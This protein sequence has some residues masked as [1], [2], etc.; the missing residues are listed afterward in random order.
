MAR[1]LKCDTDIT[2]IALC[3]I[4]FQEV[5]FS[6]AQNGQEISRVTFLTMSL[7]YPFRRLWT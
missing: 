6:G 1:N 7:S 4:L 3:T 2:S 5:Q